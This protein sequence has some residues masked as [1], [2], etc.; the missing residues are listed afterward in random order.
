[1]T[2]VKKSVFW[3]IF[4]VVFID[5]VGFGIVF[6][7]LPQV[8]RE[9]N[10]TGLQVGLVLGVYSLME[11]ILAPVLGR[12]SDRIGRR[13]V[14]LVYMAGTALSFLM[15]AFSRNF[16]WFFIA[17]ALDG[18][19]GSNIATAQAYIADVSPREQRT[20][21][22]GMWIGAAFGLG[23]A[24][25]PFLGGGLYL[26]GQQLLPDMAIGFPFLAAGILALINLGFAYFK[27]TESLTLRESEHR[28]GHR[29]FSWSTIRERLTENV[30]PLI[31]SY[32][33]VI[34]AFSQMEATFTWLSHDTF[35]L[36]DLAVYA[37]FGYLGIVMSV[38]QGGMVR[39]LAPKMGDRNMALMGCLLMV[40]SLATMPLI[41]QVA[42]LVLTAGVLAAGES[43]SNTALISSISK[44]ASEYLQGETM[45]VT[46]S[47][48]SLSRFLGPLLA[49]YCYQ[50]MGP[51]SPYL[52]SAAIMLLASL[53]CLNGYKK[54]ETPP[55]L[56]ENS[57]VSV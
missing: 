27:L 22:L 41:P 9:F 30:G 49:G 23:F 33:I 35:R 52:A 42:W 24:F 50:Q 5:I 34:F 8:A 31:L 55:S 37:L 10:L 36:D 20:R 21:N 19:A 17:R 16:M 56:S 6:P 57:P 13:P 48:A 29:T 1:M 32:A 26:A 3:I 38:V 28:I 15:L 18:I 39:K 45:G 12:L 53:L 51:A 14:L 54:V 11:F 4:F 46:Q 7:L 25:G 47:L 43:F 40:I 2:P 44:G